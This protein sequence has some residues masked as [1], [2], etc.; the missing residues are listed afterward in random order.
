MVRSSFVV[1]VPKLRLGTQL[2]KLCFEFQAIS[3]LVRRIDSKR[4]FDSAV[5]K[6]SLGTRDSSI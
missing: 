3:Q 6:R 1:L 5:P 2:S 4:S